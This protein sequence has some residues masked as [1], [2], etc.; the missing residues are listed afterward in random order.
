MCDK[1][2]EPGCHELYGHPV[3]D[4][5]KVFAWTYTEVEHNYFPEYFC[6][7]NSTGRVGIWVYRDDNGRKVYLEGVKCL[8]E[9]YALLEPEEKPLF[10]KEINAIEEIGR[11]DVC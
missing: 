4:A 11:V 2:K 7:V 8:G 6:Y 5:S 10:L 1:D 3:L 9:L